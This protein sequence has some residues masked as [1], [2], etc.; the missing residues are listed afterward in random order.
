MPTD[1]LRALAIQSGIYSRFAVDTN[2]PDGRFEE[3]YKLWMDQ[4]LAKVMAD[5][6]L[7]I[8]ANDGRVAAMATLSVKAEAGEVGLLA[9]DHEF[10]GRGYGA[11]LLRRAEEWF[12]DRKCR[13]VRIIT[14]GA[15]VP[16]CRLYEKCGYALE[17]QSHYFHFWL[18]DEAGAI[19][20][21]SPA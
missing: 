12:V 17:H 18:D 6:V 14:Q 3:M 1:V 21:H 9:V 4:S 15:N 5:E 10:R 19:P 11:S 8:R 2:F 7:V 16:A 13:A 20:R